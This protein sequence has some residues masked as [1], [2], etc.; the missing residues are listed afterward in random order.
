MV[1]SATVSVIPSQINYWPLL[2]SLPGLHHVRLFDSDAD[3]GKHNRKTEGEEN[4]ARDIFK[5]TFKMVVMF[6]LC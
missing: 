3:S 5:S 2:L 4:C 1:F 6:S